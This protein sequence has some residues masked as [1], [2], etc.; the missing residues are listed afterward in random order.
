MSPRGF[1]ITGTDTD[2]GKTRV[3][4][5]LM[6][7]LCARGLRV[8]GM[9]PVSCGGIETEAGILN[10]DVL[11]LQQHGSDPSLPRTLMNRYAF[12]QPVAP[13]LAAAMQHDTIDIGVIVDDLHR[14][15]GLADVIVLEGAGGWEV[16]ISDSE[17][18]ADIARACELPVIL[19]VGIRLGCLNHALLSSRAIADTGLPFAGWIANLIDL[20]A[21][22]VDENIATLQKRIPAP[23]LGIIPHLPGDLDAARI[24]AALD[25]DTLV[26]RGLFTE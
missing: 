21:R 17:T 25:I 24:A 22:A 3:A 10:E 15:E 5:G 19:V 23:L 14:L 11:I 8:V 12:S 7:A 20:D 2:V 26:S 16:P 18:M 1:F 13:H 9:K 4:A 6:T